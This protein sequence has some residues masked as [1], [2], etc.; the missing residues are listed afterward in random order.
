[1]HILLQVH[2]LKDPTE[3]EKQL[4]LDQNSE[5]DFVLCPYPIYENETG[6]LLGITEGVGQV[7]V[8]GDPEDS[9]YDNNLG[10]DDKPIW[11]GY[12]KNKIRNLF[13]CTLPSFMK[14]HIEN[15]MCNTKERSEIFYLYS[16]AL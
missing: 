14:Y 10:G 12:R 9:F 16:T 11:S 15:N 7:V 2:R 5:S 13:S 4:A 6:K 1:M 8:L 3:H